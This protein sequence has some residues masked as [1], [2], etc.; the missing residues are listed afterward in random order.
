VNERG[1]V[2]PAAEHDHDDLV[3]RV[4]VKRLT[5][6]VGQAAD[7]VEAAVRDEL[8]QRRASARIQTFVPIFAERAARRRLARDGSEPG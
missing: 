1:A 2:P 7:V 8:E 5:V 4:T 3:V 6:S